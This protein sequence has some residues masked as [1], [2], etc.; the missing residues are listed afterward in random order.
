MALLK[1]LMMGAEMVVIMGPPGTGKTDVVAMLSSLSSAVDPDAGPK[2]LVTGYTKS[3]ICQP[4]AKYH[5]LFESDSPFMQTLVV[6]P[7]REARD[8]H[9]FS[10]MARAQRAKPP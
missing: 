1:R 7:A 5:E 8:L 6:I 10:K 9:D 4:A 3:T 2:I